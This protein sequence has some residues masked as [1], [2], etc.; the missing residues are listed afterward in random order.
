M[1]TLKLQ[2]LKHSNVEMEKIPGVVVVHK[3]WAS[4]CHKAPYKSRVY[5][6]ASL[7]ELRAK[8]VKCV[9]PA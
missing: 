3:K 5:V 9:G 6:C 2:K 4:N 7:T 1:K 8:Q